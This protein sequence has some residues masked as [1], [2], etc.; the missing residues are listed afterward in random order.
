MASVSTLSWKPQ[1]TF[2][3]SGPVE[4]V[5]GDPHSSEEGDPDE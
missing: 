2:V 1:H 5:T 4:H 3:I